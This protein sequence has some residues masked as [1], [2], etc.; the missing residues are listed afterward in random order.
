MLALELRAPRGRLGRVALPGVGVL[1][2]ALALVLALGGSL[3][4]L[5]EGSRAT[6]GGMA[7]RGAQRL[8][9]A[10]AL[11][12]G[13]LVLAR[14]AGLRSCP[15]RRR[16]RGR[17]LLGLAGAL[18]VL[19]VALAGSR[20]SASTGLA[21][22]AAAALPGGRVGDLAAAIAVAVASVLREG[23][24]ATGRHRRHRRGRPPRTR[25]ARADRSLRPASPRLPPRPAR[26]RDR[27][28]G[29]AVRV[30]ALTSVASARVLSSPVARGATG[31]A[32]VRRDPRVPLAHRSRAGPSTATT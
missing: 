11:G 7:R 32:D 3:L 16:S 28:S 30:R 9:G 19:A 25:G 13:G 6:G 18:G 24:Y 14:G 31:G 15:G 8:W 5:A 12:T 26:P 21:R 2:R 22:L 4:F 23:T 20:P 29:A 10:V 27:L 17:P 1:A